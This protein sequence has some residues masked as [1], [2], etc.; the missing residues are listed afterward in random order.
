MRYIPHTDLEIQSM[1]ETIGV[2][3]VSDLFQSI[4][5]SIRLQKLLNLPQALSEPELLSHL[6]N[7]SRKNETVDHYSSFLGAGSYHHYVPVTVPMLITRGEFATSYTPYQPEISQGTL[8]AVFE[9]QTMVASLLG[10]EIANASNYDGSTAL[11][12]AVLMAQRLQKKKKVIL[13]EAIH[14]EY[15][16]VV[17]STV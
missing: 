15:R 12:E 2:S 5:S 17:Q 4:P 8:Q 14:P 16:Q 10:M 9:F 1:C 7:L 13:S 6:K 3:G 11:A